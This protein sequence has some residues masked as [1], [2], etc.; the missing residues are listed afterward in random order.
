MQISNGERK[1]EGEDSVK[2]VDCLRGRLLAERAASK[3]AK[4]EAQQ[5]EIKLMELE[6]L[7]TQEAKSRNKAEKK[8]KFLT[9]KLES[10]NIFHLSDE[11]EYISSISSTITKEEEEEGNRN[12]QARISEAFENQELKGEAIFQKDL[13]NLKQIDSSFSLSDDN[14]ST[15]EGASTSCAFE[16]HLPEFKGLECEMR[17]DKDVKSPR[18]GKIVEQRNATFE[19]SL[20]SASGKSS[21][22]MDQQSDFCWRSIDEGEGEGEGIN[23]RNALF[24]DSLSSASDQQSGDSISIRSCADEQ[25]QDSDSQI[26]DSMALVVVDTSQKIHRIDPDALDATVREVL[27]TLRRAK[28]QLRSSMERRRMKVI[29]VGR[30]NLA[31]KTSTIFI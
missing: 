1:M 3:N 9:K 11:S 16:V 24:E 12:Q 6:K 22:N 20:S 30:T 4:A 21:S 29:G 15:A 18:I 19:D 10:I 26:D 28:E 8:L 2:T 7:L 17:R 14:S 23:Q 13:G 5:L 31:V 25:G 27:D